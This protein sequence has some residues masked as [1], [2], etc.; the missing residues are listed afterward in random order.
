MSCEGVRLFS[1][2]MGS[3]SR[4]LSRNTIRRYAFDRFIL[5]ASW[6]MDEVRG[7]D[8]RRKKDKSGENDGCGAWD[9][10]SEM[11]PEFRWVMVRTVS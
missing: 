8:E 7:G 1:K 9:G 5:V 11:S 6:R 2:M 3:Y 4:V 10:A